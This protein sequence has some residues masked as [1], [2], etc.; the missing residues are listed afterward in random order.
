[1]EARSEQRERVESEPSASPGAR[2]PDNFT[3]I[4]GLS[5]D[6]AGDSSGLTLDGLIGLPG[7][8]CAAWSGLGAA[9][10]DA[11]LHTFHNA[12]KGGAILPSLA[13]TCGAAMGEAMG[14]GAEKFTECVLDTSDV[15]AAACSVA[16]RPALVLADNSNAMR[17]VRRSVVQRG[18][19]GV[20]P[21]AG[22]DVELIKAIVHKRDPTTDD[23]FALTRLCRWHRGS[24]ENVEANGILAERFLLE[25]PLEDPA[26]YDRTICTKANADCINYNTPQ[27]ICHAVQAKFA[28]NAMRLKVEKAGGRQNLL[29]GQQLAASQIIYPD[30]YGITFMD[31]AFACGADRMQHEVAQV[32]QSERRRDVIGNA[33][34]CSRIDRTTSL[35][36]PASAAY[37]QLSAHMGQ[38][39]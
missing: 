38:Q 39:N 25:L 13:E 12:G 29:P 4:C 7:G 30:P 17:Q 28:N 27:E 15:P 33:H 11:C 34:V 36:P 20:Y 35:L 23:V 9:E 31:M 1:M 16:L 14:L 24:A 21:D 19:R 26:G 3:A 18:V 37:A 8:F 32:L 10:R 2:I 22:T 5:A 6:T